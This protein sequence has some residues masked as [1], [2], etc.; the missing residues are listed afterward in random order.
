MMF[1]QITLAGGAGRTKPWSFAASISVQSILVATALAV[2]MLHVAK[3]E[4]KIPPNILML[5]SLA[6]QPVHQV[7]SRSPAPNPNLL[8]QSVRT[9]KAFHA[10]SHIPDKVAMGPDLPGAPTYAIDN[11]NDG[12]GVVCCGIP[13]IIDL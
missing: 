6:P 1:E 9:Y 7:T 3:L 11:I 12:G 5:R 2:P 10:P 8:A 4:T 13:G